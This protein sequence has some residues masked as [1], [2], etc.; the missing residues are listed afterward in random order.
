MSKRYIAEIQAPAY[1][2]FF[3]LQ[4]NFVAENRGHSTAETSS[5]DRQG[6]CRQAGLVSK[7][8]QVVPGRGSGYLHDTAQIAIDRG[9]DTVGESR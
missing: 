4:E 5:A 7:Q 6:P 9:M 3:V 2:P 8:G 1:V